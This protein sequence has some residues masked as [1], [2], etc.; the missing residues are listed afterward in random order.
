MARSAI[1]AS[2]VEGVRAISHESNERAALEK[3]DHLN[4]YRFV[5]GSAIRKFRLS[6]PIS[7]PA[8]QYWRIR[9]D[10]DE[11][12]RRRLRHLK[13]ALPLLV[14]LRI[15]HSTCGPSESILF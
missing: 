12:T 14:M 4:V 8:V 10:S 1:A 2:S 7:I 6:E 15:R 5:P 3:L 11:L 13:T 9:I